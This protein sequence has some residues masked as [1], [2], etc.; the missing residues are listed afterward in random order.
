MKGNKKGIDLQQAT[1]L[2]HVVLVT[3]HI[4]MYFHNI[5]SFPTL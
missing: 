1:N 4:P 5:D 3:Y 2:V